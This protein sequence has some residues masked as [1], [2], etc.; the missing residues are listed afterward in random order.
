MCHGSW[1]MCHGSWHISVVHFIDSIVQRPKTGIRFHFRNSGPPFS[2]FSHRKTWSYKISASTDHFKNFPLFPL[3]FKGQ[4]QVLD[5]I[6]GLPDHD[7]WIS[8]AQKLTHT[9]FQSQRTILRIFHCF[10]CSSKAKITLKISFPGLGTIIFVFPVP[11]NMVI[12]NFSSN[13]PF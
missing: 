11:K 4:K 9:K 2:C 12:Q 13:G 1:H 10:H 8:R 3:F 5:F 7:F 6:S